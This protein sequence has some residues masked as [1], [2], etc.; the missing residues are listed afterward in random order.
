MHRQLGHVTD[1][2]RNPVDLDLGVPAVLPIDG[3]KHLLVGR[4][5]AR[6]EAARANVAVMTHTNAPVGR[7]SWQM[8]EGIGLH[9]TGLAHTRPPRR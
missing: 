2:Q 7:G 6:Q 3:C 5:I 8:A 4:E 9:C 1:V